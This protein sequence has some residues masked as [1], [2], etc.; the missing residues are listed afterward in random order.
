[1][2]ETRLLYEPETRNLDARDRVER[3]TITR[4]D[5]HVNDRQPSD[6]ARGGFIFVLAMAAVLVWVLSRL[7]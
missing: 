2:G 7:F 1:M 3:L 4:T 5:Y 6:H